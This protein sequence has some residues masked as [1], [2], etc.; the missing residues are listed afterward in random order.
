MLIQV[1]VIQ[2]QLSGNV[3][4]ELGLTIS[5]N[6]LTEILRCSPCEETGMEFVRVYLI[7]KILKKC[8]FPEMR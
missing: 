1:K 7:E 3:E 4:E 5:T 2:K 8:V 6:E